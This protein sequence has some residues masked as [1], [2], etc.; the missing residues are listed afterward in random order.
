MIGEDGETASRK[1]GRD[2]DGIGVKTPDGICFHSQQLL[3][4]QVGRNRIIIQHAIFV[5]SR[6]MKLSNVQSSSESLSKNVGS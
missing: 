5:R 1:G 2:K 4:W 6:D 3:Y